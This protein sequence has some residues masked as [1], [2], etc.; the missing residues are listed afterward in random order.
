MAS[1]KPS[2]SFNFEQS[3]E[4]LNTLVEKMEQGDIP[5]EQSLEY[6]EKG[7]NL[8]S[9]CQKALKQAEQKVQKLSKQQG[10]ETLEPFADDE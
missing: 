10:V 1:K 6:F 2:D 9:G 5:L 4:Q 8:I 7:V 3:L